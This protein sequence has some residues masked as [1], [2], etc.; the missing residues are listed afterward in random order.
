[1]LE[2]L[3]PYSSNSCAGGDSYSMSEEDHSCAD[4]SSAIGNMSGEDH[5]DGTLLKKTLDDIDPP[6]SFASFGDIKPLFQNPKI[7]VSGFG[8]VSLPLRPESAELLKGLASKAPFG[9]GADTLY[10]DN[11]RQSWQLEPDVVQIL[12]TEWK[13]MINKILLDAA[14]DLG[15]S[16]RNVEKMGIKANL[17]KVLL[18]EKGGHFKPHRDTEKEEGMFAT[19]VI[20]LP[21]NFQGG[22]VRVSHLGQTKTLESS[23]DCDSV[24][25]YSAFYADC[26]HELLPVTEGW[27]MCL[28]YNIV[29]SSPD[30]ASDLRAFEREKALQET[31]K[32]FCAQWRGC[33]SPPSVL[34]YSLD[35]AYT[36]QRCRFGEL[37]GRDRLVANAMLHAKG[38]DGS[39]LFDVLLVVFTLETEDYKRDRTGV[40]C[41]VDQN[42]EKIENSIEDPMYVGGDGL[43]RKKEDLTEDQQEQ[44]R[45][46]FS[47]CKDPKKNPKRFSAFNHDRFEEGFEEEP[48]MGNE[49]GERT[50]FYRAGALI[51]KP[52][53]MSGK[54]QKTP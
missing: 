15:I 46:G 51:L 54:R 36:L 12:G 13:T 30:Q 8:E 38:D 2:N 3:N 23:A 27:R 33:P 14:Y 26:E 22:D 19:L 53:A 35:H 16:N 17:Y 44:V 39:S 10:D 5:F 47:F 34:G 7:I 28:V 48:Y 11:V 43:L 25:K 18:Y 9:L 29:C 50:T 52:R 31:L 20:Q 42:D 1:M 24:L 40:R 37:K 21:S 41:V 32:V 4:S 49:G 45:E 6:G